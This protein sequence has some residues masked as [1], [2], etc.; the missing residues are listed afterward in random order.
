MASY[1]HLGAKHRMLFSY[2]PNQEP[3]PLETQTQEG[4]ESRAGF[5][6]QR[7]LRGRR[8]SLDLL[9][10]QHPFGPILQGSFGG[11]GVTVGSKVT[12]LACGK[13]RVGS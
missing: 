8:C 10:P 2:Q 12:F 5:F 9:L 7:V 11:T 1:R 3:W 4:E 6:G 13:L